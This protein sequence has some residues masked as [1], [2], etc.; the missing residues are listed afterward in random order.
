VSDPSD[1]HDLLGT[2]VLLGLNNLLCLVLG[3]AFAKL[4]F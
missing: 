4:V 2:A 1:T 3:A